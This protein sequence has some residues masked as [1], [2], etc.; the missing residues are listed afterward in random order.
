MSNKLTYNDIN[1]NIPKDVKNYGIKRAI[2]TTV[3]FILGEAAAVFGAYLFSTNSNEAATVITFAIAIAIPF[4]VTGFPMK[5]IDRS[6]IGMIVKV[7]VATT[8]TSSMKEGPMHVH[9]N[10]DVNLYIKEENGNILVKKAYQGEAKTKSGFK[11]YANGDI[12][13]HVYGTEPIILLP[14]KPSM[15][16]QCAVCDTK[17]ANQDFCPSC[18][19]TL[20]KLSDSNAKMIKKD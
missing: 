15:D 3:Y 18:G 6:Y 1:V 7:N 4:F 13:V 17:I 9:Q 16:C 8:T 2:L 5:I 20:I 14:L 11:K 19:H 10:N 12:V